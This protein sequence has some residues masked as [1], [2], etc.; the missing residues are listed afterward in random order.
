MTESPLSIAASY[1]GDSYATHADPLVYRYLSAPLILLLKDVD[2]Y[3]L[4]VA[5]GSG[6]LGRGL[7]A[8][9]GVDL[10]WH[11]LEVSRLPRKVRADAHRL[12]FL[13][14][15][16]AAAGCAFGINHFPDAVTAV[17]EMAR[18][19]PL[20]GLLT[21]VR[22]EPQYTP[23]QAVLEVIERHTGSAR[24][25]TG[26][27]VE[28]MSQ[29]VGSPEAVNELLV[30][31]ELIPDVRVV[32]VEVPWPGAER[33]VDYRLSMSE[34]SRWGTR[35]ERIRED[36]IAAVGA[37]GEEQVRWRP[38]VVLGIGRRD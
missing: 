33:F 31:A 6:A 21:W 12:P 30:A 26:R 4:D 5:T 36:A 18:V 32:E 15:S 37:L 25:P 23:K 10:S 14:D 34:R 24:S 11:Q 19:A 9:V 29:A 17:S 16:F 27:L 1:D 8:V 3:V 20:V 13:P 38:P 22:P 28:E 35:A 2:G 7:P